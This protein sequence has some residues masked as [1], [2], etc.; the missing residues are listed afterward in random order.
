LT[1]LGVTAINKSWADGREKRHARKF[2]SKIN[3]IE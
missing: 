3:Q 2:L 1:I